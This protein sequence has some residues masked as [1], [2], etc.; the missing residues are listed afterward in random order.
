[1]DDMIM[2]SSPQSLPLNSF[3]ALEELWLSDETDTSFV[4][5]FLALPPTGKLRN[6]TFYFT[7]I[8]PDKFMVISDQ[9]GTYTSL[10][11]LALDVDLLDASDE[12]FTEDPVPS[13]WSI[14]K[15][16]SALES[17][18][19]FDITI[20]FE[21]MLPETYLLLLARHWPDLRSWQSSH[22]SWSAKARQYSYIS[23]TAFFNILI[24]MPYV[25]ELPISIL[26]SDELP[27]EDTIST[28]V[29]RGQHPYKAELWIERLGDKK[30][31][32][33]TIEMMIRR[34]APNISNLECLSKYV[35]SGQHPTCPGETYIS[36]GKI[37]R[38]VY[39][40]DD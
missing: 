22:R 31:H 16:L 17:L 33:L 39:V 23:L 14:T 21:Y 10:S 9:L 3:P 34:V 7:D 15:P 8:S 20:N 18:Q 2:D 27:S 24:H 1:V 40:N 37:G 38:W 29:L 6:V 11:I 25:E 36:R 4:S 32:L 5:T 12:M 28:L 13:S 30:D 19:S 26:L 35:F